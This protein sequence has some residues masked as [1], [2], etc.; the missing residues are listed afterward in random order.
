MK[1][2]NS[3]IFG[4]NI[5]RIRNSCCLTQ[6]QTVAQLQVLG[7]PI[8]RSSYSLVELGRGKIFVSGLVGLKQ[9]FRVNYS[10]FFKSVPTS[11]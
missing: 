4:Q 5:Q 6:E 10:E 9:I 2:I 8:S 1:V 11:R 7:S 3:E